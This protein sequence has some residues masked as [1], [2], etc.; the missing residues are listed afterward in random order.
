[1]N[2]I[3]S[4]I[5]R[6]SGQNN[7]MEQLSKITGDINTIDKEIYRAAIEKCSKCDFN[8]KILSGRFLSMKDLDSATSTLFKE[9]LAAHESYD[10]KNKTFVMYQ[11]KSKKAKPP[12]EIIDPKHTPT[13]VFKSDWY[14]LVRQIE[15]V[16]R[17]FLKLI[18]GVAE[19]KSIEEF[20]K[21]FEDA[22]ELLSV[23]Y[24]GGVHVTDADEKFFMNIVNTFKCS[25][26]IINEFLNPM[27]DVRKKIESNSH[28]IEKAFKSK[29]MQELGAVTSAFDVMVILEKFIISKYRATITGNNK[30]YVKLFTELID[31]SST[32]ELEGTKFLDI[33]ESLNLEELSKNK[34]AYKFAVGAKDI[35]S[36]IVKNESLDSDEIIQ[37]VHNI[38]GEDEEQAPEEAP[39]EAKEFDDLL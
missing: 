24:F 32:A 1:M 3:D 17:K 21:A 28:I 37:R 30:H 26:I 29:P 10:I 4:Q 12:K 35:I 31:P 15:K 36:S 16:T 38:F 6:I 7:Y 22:P 25:R 5:N 33:M 34:K 18:F 8:L 20:K 13:E 23:S 9:F 27:Y 19:T 2:D 11:K 14:K 39:E